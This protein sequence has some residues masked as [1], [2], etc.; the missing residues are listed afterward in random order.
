MWPEFVRKITLLL[1]Y[2]R[3]NSQNFRPRYWKPGNW[4]LQANDLQSDSPKKDQEGNH[5]PNGSRHSSS[6]T[7]K[8]SLFMDESDTNKKDTIDKNSLLEISTLMANNLDINNFKPYDYSEFGSFNYVIRSRNYQ[9]KPNDDDQDENRLKMKPNKL[10]PIQRNKPENDQQLNS[11][12][13]NINSKEGKKLI[14]QDR[15]HPNQSIEDLLQNN[16]TGSNLKLG[17]IPGYVQVSGSTENLNNI[18]DNT[19]RTTDFDYSKVTDDIYKAFGKQKQS[20]YSYPQKITVLKTSRSNKPQAESNHE[21]YY[22]NDLVEN[23]K[24]M[25]GSKSDF[26]GQN[27]RSMIVEKGVNSANPNSKYRDGSTRLVPLESSRIDSRSING[28]ANSNMS[29]ATNFSQARNNKLMK[30]L[31]EF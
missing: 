16:L 7:Q 26:F 9:G 22:L 20:K 13:F 4:F 24:S 30:I 21:E 23:T 1:L 15:N 11:T 17:K 18:G 25:L 31:G 28:G 8:N 29:S 19:N 14:K 6:R 2:D 5:R 27:Q 3:L 10:N 12:S